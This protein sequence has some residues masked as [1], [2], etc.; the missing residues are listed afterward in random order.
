MS[1]KSPPPPP[2]RWSG[3]A[4]A[5][6][7]PAAAR[8]GPP[9]PAHGAASTS[10]QQ[11]K[12]FEAVH[13][14]R[15]ARET[16]PVDQLVP[17][18]GDLYQLRAQDRQVLSRPSGVYNFVRVQGETRNQ[19]ATM[20]SSGTPHAGLAAGRPVLYAGTAAFESGRLQWWSNYSG[21]YQPNAEFA[22]QADLP[23]DKFVPW[24]RLSMGGVGL[25]R[26]MLADRRSAATPEVK[27]PEV[28]KAEAKPAAADSSAKSP[29]DPAMRR[30]PGGH[31]EKS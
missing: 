14:P 31:P 30:E 18:S 25:Q 7:K 13:R 22:R 2:V 23:T 16:A 19:T 21:T 5:Q 1:G 24:Q 12:A 20:V 27:V 6:A 11:S 29:A 4:P 8:P 17:V 9:A 26:G 15:P 28:R 3:A 10:L